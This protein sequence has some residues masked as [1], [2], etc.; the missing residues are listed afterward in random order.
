MMKLSLKTL[1]I[2]IL[3]II[4]FPRALYAAADDA[5]I[6]GVANPAVFITIK[7]RTEVSSDII[8]L[9]DVC[10]V[11]LAAGFF[12]DISKILSIEIG[13]SPSAFNARKLYPYEIKNILSS[14][15]KLPKGAY[16]CMKGAEFC[17]ISAY[18]RSHT[19]KKTAGLVKREIEKAIA[20]LF[21]KKY[22]EKFNIDA[23][24]TI[25]VALTCGLNASFVKKFLGNEEV[26]IDILDYKSGMANISVCSRKNVLA[27]L[28][29]RIMRSA[30]AAVALEDIE[31]GSLI[32]LNKIT[33]REIEIYAEKHSELYLVSA[34]PVSGFADLLKDSRNGCEIARN[35]Q[36]G[37]LI[38]K[39]FVHKKFAIAAGQRIRMSVYNGNSTMAFD[40]IA[41][42]SGSLGDEI[43]VINPRTR[44]KYR[45]LVTGDGEAESK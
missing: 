43:S 29:A 22:G 41:E 17:V 21:M 9:K 36:A 14:R 23:D 1:F 12:V 33:T 8:Y 34:A 31:K 6:S 18:N 25:S 30:I 42:Q 4:F 15:L 3:F 44:K 13:A 20:A 19:D 11:K 27:K 32:N 24:A 10:D 2:F 38:Y 28:Y 45:A 5:S 26:K 16:Y 35:I 40:A 37:G 39:R 7:P